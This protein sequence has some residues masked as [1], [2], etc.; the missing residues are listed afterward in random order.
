M[1]SL[2]NISKITAKEKKHPMGSVSSSIGKRLFVWNGD[3]SISGIKENQI[4]HHLTLTQIVPPSAHN[5]YPNLSSLA[6]IRMS[7]KES[8]TE[9]LTVTK[10]STMM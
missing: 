7:K 6:V 5:V 2:R 9:T 8:K 1:A 3:T 4:T 10:T